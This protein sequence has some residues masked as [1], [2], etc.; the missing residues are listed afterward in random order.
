MMSDCLYMLD[1]TCT[2]HPD[3]SEC[4]KCNDR[5]IS[6]DLPKKWIDPLIIIDRNRNRIESL[7]NILAGGSAFLMGGGPSANDMELEKLAM[8]GVWTL[9]INNAAGHPKVRPQAMICADPP[10]KFSHSI[11]LDPGMMKFIPTPK[12]KP[13][14]GTLRRKTAD[15]FELLGKSA[16]D[17]PNVWG[18]QRESWLMP[19]DSFFRSNGAL[20]GNHKSGVERTGQPKTVCTFLL[21][22]RVLYYL[23]ARRIYLLGV[24]FRMT[25]EA[26]YSFGQ[27]R[28][29]GACRSNSGQFVVIN[30]WLC[31]MQ[32]AGV[33]ERFGL[34]VYNTY[35]RSGLR[36]FPYVPFVDAVE[37]CRGG[38]EIVP[39]LQNYYDPVK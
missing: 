35:E 30:N 25:P 24:D 13:R 26:G 15:G 20:W 21:G 33:F 17:C 38:C 10:R 3:Q 39:D 27:A 12:M 37:D 8:R 34:S 4:K 7:R 5:I 31:K 29:E 36:A 28:D 9:A 32:E 23:G 14:R 16:C 19:D 1:K 22:L 11:W 18:F 2:L 6:S